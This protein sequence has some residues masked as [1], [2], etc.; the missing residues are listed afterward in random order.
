MKLWRGVVQG[1]ENSRHI[2]D[3]Y[4]V[5]HILHGFLFYGATWLVPPKAPWLARLVVAML[6]E[7]AWDLV[8]NFN[9]IISRYRAGTADRR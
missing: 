2:A 8:E 1:S 4:T 3:W 9:W 6:V 5:S 7:G